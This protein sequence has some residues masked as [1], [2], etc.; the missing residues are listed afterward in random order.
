MPITTIPV[1]LPIASRSFLSR[2]TLLTALATASASG[3]A[4]AQVT[5]MAPEPANIVN[6]SASGFLEVPQDWLTMSLNTTKEGA[7]E[8]LDSNLEFFGCWGGQ[9]VVHNA[10]GVSEW[11]DIHISEK[12]LE[13]TFESG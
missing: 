9:G 8:I 4:L 11:A 12:T 1:A 7:E 2:L 3:A 5:P 6:I 13:S 10:N